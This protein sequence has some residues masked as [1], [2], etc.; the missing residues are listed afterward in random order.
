[1]VLE[2]TD[3][4]QENGQMTQ[5]NGQMAQENVQLTQEIPKKYPRNTQK[6]ASL[7]PDRIISLL[8]SDP[9]YTRQQLAK[10]FGVSESTIKRCLDA[11]VKNGI[12]T[13]EGPTKKGRWIVN[14]H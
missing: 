3:M 7:L 13:R 10:I 12:L 9:T 2:A 11:L 6:T 8:E 5:E 14:K 1:M 4:T